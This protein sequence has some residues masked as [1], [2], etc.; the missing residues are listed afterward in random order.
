M[1]Q[2]LVNDLGEQERV[3]RKPMV[4]EGGRSTYGGEGGLG[5]GGVPM[6]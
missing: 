1:K 4:E 2:S 6:Y 5:G 3:V